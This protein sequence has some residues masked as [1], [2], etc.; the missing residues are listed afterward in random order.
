MFLWLDA[1][2]VDKQQESLAGSHLTKTSKN[3]KGRHPVYV[4]PPT[5]VPNRYHTSAL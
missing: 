4:G 5:A 2:P 3:G 1:L